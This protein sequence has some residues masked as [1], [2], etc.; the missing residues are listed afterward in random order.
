MLL[1]AKMNSLFLFTKLRFVHTIS[2]EM[3]LEKTAERQTWLSFAF[4]R[5]NGSAFLYHWDTWPRKTTHRCRM[6][7]KSPDTA[8]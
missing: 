5:N 8:L 3:P 7:L 4:R 6:G 2:N 1:M